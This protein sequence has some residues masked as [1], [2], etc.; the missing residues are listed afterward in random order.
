M[1]NER[2][3]SK[4]SDYEVADVTTENKEGNCINLF[5]SYSALKWNNY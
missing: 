3:Y 1:N 2:L 4:I 5:H